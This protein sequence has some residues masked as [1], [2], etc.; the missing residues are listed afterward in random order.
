MFR[1][2][3]VA[4]TVRASYMQYLIF[5]SPQCFGMNTIIIPIK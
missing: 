4:G 1:D 3:F 5:T 2:Y